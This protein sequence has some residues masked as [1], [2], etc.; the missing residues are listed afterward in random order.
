[1]K[2]IETKRPGVLGL[3]GQRASRRSREAQNNFTPIV[4]AEIISKAEV[5][6]AKDGFP[7]LR[8]VVLVLFVLYG[9]GK[10]SRRLGHSLPKM[11]SAWARREEPETS[12]Q[13]RTVKRNFKLL[14]GAY[15]D[16]LRR[17]RREAPEEA[18]SATAM[19]AFLLES[20]GDGH[21]QIALRGENGEA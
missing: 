15:E 8:D 5:Q 2:R 20:Y 13:R 4:D 7:Y 12:R 6:A 18:R 1:M 17:W 9:S 21:L 19:F 10:L 16:A 11:I 3:H 14:K